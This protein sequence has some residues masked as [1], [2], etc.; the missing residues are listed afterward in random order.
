MLSLKIPP[1]RVA[2]GK[3][4]FKSLQVGK[5]AGKREKREAVDFILDSGVDTADRFGKTDLINFCKSR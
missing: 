5:K 3:L 2:T 4:K 1:N